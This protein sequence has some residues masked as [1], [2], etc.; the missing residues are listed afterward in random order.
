MNNYIFPVGDWSGDGHA[1]V[2]EFVVQS[3]K[4]IEEIRETHFANAWI[5]DLCSEY[6]DDKIYFGIFEDLDDSQKGIQFLKEMVLEH[7]L[8]CDGLKGDGTFV[9]DEALMDC[10][11]DMDYHSM[12]KVWV[13]LLNSFNPELQLKIVS[14]ALSKYEIKYKGY[15]VDKIDGDIHFCGYDD[16]GRHLNLPGYGVWKGHEM[17]FYLACN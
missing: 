7:K 17:E 13:Y 6:E 10:D 14:G 9:D 2:A 12:I 15:G 11:I 5:G 4:S 1:F 16:K 8:N 3:P